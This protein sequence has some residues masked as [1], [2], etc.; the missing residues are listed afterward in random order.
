[1]LQL[2]MLPT[3]AAITTAHSLRRPAPPP[4]PAAPARS[5]ALW[6]ITPVSTVSDRVASRGSRANSRFVMLLTG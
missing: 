5:S 1:M 2:C 4:V 3:P 6:D